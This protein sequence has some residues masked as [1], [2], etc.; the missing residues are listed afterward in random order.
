MK[1]KSN[2]ML[3][4]LK[5][6][7]ATE[8]KPEIFDRV[9]LG[10]LIGMKIVKVARDIWGFWQDKNEDKDVVERRSAKGEEW[11]RYRGIVLRCQNAEE[12]KNN[13]EETEWRYRG[14]VIRHNGCGRV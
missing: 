10:I 13:T 7:A 1:Q 3:R 4:K 2:Q 12:S 6:P 11:M 8:Q 14:M 5:N 9:S